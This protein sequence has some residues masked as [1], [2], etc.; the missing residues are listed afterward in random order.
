MGDDGDFVCEVKTYKTAS[1]NDFIM[2]AVTDDRLIK[3]YSQVKPKTE[4]VRRM[5]D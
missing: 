2:A 1:R 3:V 4:S 5:E